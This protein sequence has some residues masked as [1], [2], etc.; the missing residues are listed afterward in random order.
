MKILLLSDIH[1]N[2]GNLKELVLKAKEREFELILIAGDL[3]S[4]GEEKETME[5]IKEIKKLNKKVFAV[6]GN[7][8]T[9]ASVLLLE[10]EGISL[11]SKKEKF[12]GFVFVGFGGATQSIGQIVF[13]EEEIYEKLKSLIKENKEKIFL[14]TH[15]PPKNSRL[16]ESLSGKHI[17]SI[18]VRK[19]IEQFK[20]EFSVCGHCHEAF[21]EEKIKETLC[22]NASSVKEKRI[23]LLDTK[24]KKIERIEL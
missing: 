12:K 11:H 10:K 4:F 9:K 24:T 1:S 20:P 7:L 5:V 17:G 2:T 22:I 13:S 16:D 15:S 19:I 23:F 21:G 8:D 3:T 6:P 14:L 18:A